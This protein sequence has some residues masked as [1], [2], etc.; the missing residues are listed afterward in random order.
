MWMKNALPLDLWS[1]AVQCF[2][3]VLVAQLDQA[4]QQDPE[5]Q[6]LPGE[7]NILS[8]P[9]IYIPNASYFNI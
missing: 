7:N 9:N 8:V 2:P 5:D 1:Q 6:Q 3:E 4:D